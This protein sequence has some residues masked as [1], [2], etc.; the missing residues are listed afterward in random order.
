MR[1]TSMAAA[2]ALCGIGLA[3]CA[4]TSGWSSPDVATSSRAGWGPNGKPLY[5][6]MVYSNATPGQED[7]FN[8]WYD[9]IHAP[10]MIEG[11]DFVWAQR[12]ELNDKGVAGKGSPSLRTRQFMVMFAFETND[13]DAAL[14]EVNARLAMPRNT[15]SP[16][17]DYGSLQ[18]VTWRALGPVTTKKDAIRLLAEE[19]AA[20]NVPKPGAPHLP[21]AY[22]GAQPG[23]PGPDGAGPPGSDAAPPR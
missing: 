19:E 10:V 15:R 22:L 9:R 7:E 3:G 4:S 8:R 14:K 23:P 12:F 20:G 1:M 17:I 18:A 21:G 11:G 6:S 13:I 16:S 5:I 2:I